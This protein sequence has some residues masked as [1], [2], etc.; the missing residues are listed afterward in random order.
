MAY[1]VPPFKSNG[2]SITAAEWDQYVRANFEAAVPDIFEA[3]SDLA[4]GTG[5]NAGDRLPVGSPGTYL[6]ANSAA[7]LGVSWQENPVVMLRSSVSQNVY[8]TT[9][10]RIAFNVVERAT[11][12]MLASTTGNFIQVPRAGVYKF[13]YALEVARGVPFAQNDF[14]TLGYYIALYLQGPF[15]NVLLDVWY[16]DQN[17]P[18]W[19]SLQWSGSFAANPGAGGAVNLLMYLNRSGYLGPVIVSNARLTAALVD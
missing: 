6:R 2:Q 14:P 7:P 11:G 10:T 8:P 17:P 19:N 1:S 18:M 9:N 13:Q 3:E 15:G 16:R 5:S 4:V 12:G